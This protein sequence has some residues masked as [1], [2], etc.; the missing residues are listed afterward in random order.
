MRIGRAGRSER[1]VW[2]LDLTECNI[3]AKRRH[4]NQQARWL[5][6]GSDV[7]CVSATLAL[8]F[9]AI[10]PK[11]SAPPP[12]LYEQPVV[13]RMEMQPDTPVVVHHKSSAGTS[14]HVSGRRFRFGEGGLALA[15]CG[16]VNFDNI[17]QPLPTRR[18]EDKML[19]NL[20]K[21][22]MGSSGYYQRTGQFEPLL[23]ALL[24]DPVLADVPKKPTVADIDKLIGV[25]LGSAMK[26]SI[27]KMD[28]TS[29][30]VA[31]LNTASV[32]ELKAELE[33]KV[34][35]MEQGQLGHR[36]ISW[37]HVWGN[38]CLTYNNEKLLNDDALLR[39][40]GIKNNDQACYAYCL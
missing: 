32:R 13:L 12:T 7:L 31:V 15:F 29:F 40:F 34:D 22:D 21:A 9:S 18:A 6:Q 20:R 24:D 16:S 25:E 37:K 2:W 19:L 10:L 23:A 4:T 39:E 14:L 3:R 5:K 27:L 38:F 8:C 11:Y 1:Q 35:S 36:H 17:S 33:K 30:D 26:L 28:N